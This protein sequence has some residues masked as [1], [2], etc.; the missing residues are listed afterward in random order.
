L[1][2]G[3][4]CASTTGCRTARPSR[5]WSRWRSPPQPDHQRHP[6][7][8]QPLSRGPG[9]CRRAG[10]PTGAPTKLEA[11]QSR[12]LPS[13]TSPADQAHRQGH[14]QPNPQT[15]YEAHHSDPR[16]SIVIGTSMGR[17]RPLRW[18]PSAHHLIQAPHAGQEHLSPQPALCVADSLQLLGVSRSLLLYYSRLLQVALAGR[19][20]VLRGGR[21]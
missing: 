8:A 7:C 21:R 12:D 10:R 18:L 1:G 6:R 19:Q 17:P 20:V 13:P 3:G 9:S 16:S 2:P 14:N 5:P 4:R 15:N 11:G